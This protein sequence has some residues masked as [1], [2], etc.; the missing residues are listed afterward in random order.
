MAFCH[1]SEIELDPT[2]AVYEKINYRTDDEA[3]KEILSD[4]ELFH[5]INNTNNDSLISY[6]LK[7]QNTIIPYEKYDLDYNRLK[8]ELTKYRRLT[9]WDSLY[10]I[11][12]F[13]IHTSLDSQGLR[14]S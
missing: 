8:N 7:K 12:L 2:Y 11:V 4:L 13:I 6:A 9:E 10:L 3:L 1:L 14:M 5:R